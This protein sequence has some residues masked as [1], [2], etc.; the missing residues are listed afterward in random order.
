MSRS[1]AM[2][3]IGGGLIILAVFL[4]GT[5]FDFNSEALDS[6]PLLILFLAGLGVALFLLMGKRTI[7]AYC[8]IAALTL[9]LVMIVELVRADAFDLTVQIVVLIIGVILALMGSLVHSRES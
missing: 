2:G 9:S 5:G 3:V 7:A 4:T 6:T 8:A 1:N